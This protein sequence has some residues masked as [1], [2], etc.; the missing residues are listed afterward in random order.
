MAW[1][2]WCSA[3]VVGMVL[4]AAACGDSDPSASGG[5]SGTTAT[6]SASGGAFPGD[7]HTPATGCDPGFV[8]CGD[9][10]ARVEDD[11]RH[12]GA[13][14]T[15]CNLTTPENDGCVAG[16]CTGTACATEGDAPCPE[17]QG[18]AT[19]PKCDGR[20]VDDDTNV[21]HC[22]SCT[23]RC[24]DAALCIEGTCTP[25]GSGTACGEALTWDAG[26]QEDVGFR[27]SSGLSVPHV[28]ACAGSDPLPTRFF[29]VQTPQDVLQ[30]RARAFDG[31]PVAIEIFDEVACNGA[32]SVACAPPA[33]LAQVAAPQAPVGSTRWIAVGLGGVAADQAAAISIDN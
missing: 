33:D 4:S 18:C 12:C 15:P 29:R 22:G 19:G 23:N 30:V 16:A 32:A 14:D 24:A 17:G 7:P 2:K 20:C 5:G 25:T 11:G 28:F 27:F 21:D 6:T 3:A 10:C 9:V 8:P 13:C 26:T 31:T 1:T